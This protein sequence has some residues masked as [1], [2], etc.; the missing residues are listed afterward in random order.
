MVPLTA[1]TVW[2]FVVSAAEPASPALNA[3]TPAVAP[4]AKPAPTAETLSSI[5]SAYSER[6]GSVLLQFGYDQFGEEPPRR[7]GSGGVQADYTLGPGDE[8]LVTLRGQKSSSKRHV[9]DATGLLTA[10]DVRPVVAQGLTLADLRAQL[11]NAVTASF[12]DT[13]VYVSVTEIRR[14]GVLVT[15]AVARPGRQEV[16]AF[17]TLIDALTAAGG[18]TRAGSLRRIRLFHAHAAGGTVTGGAPSNGLPIDLYDLF[19]TG[20][21]ANAGIRLRDGDRVFVPPLGPTVALAGPFKRP[22][23]YELPPGEDRLPVAVATEMAGGL[24]RPGSHRALRYAI[25][26]NGEERVEEL[27]E[28]DAPP[29]TDGDLLLLAPRRENRSGGLRLDGHVLRPG[30]RALERTPTIATLVTA[31]DLG[32]APYLPFAVLAS[33]S[34]DSRARVLRPIDLRAVLNGRDRRPLAESD[35]LYVLGADEVDFLTSEPVLDLLRGAREPAANACRGLVVLARALTAQPDGPLANGPQARAAAGLTGGRTPCPPLFEAV[36]DLL[37]FALEHSSLLMGGVARPGFYP[38]AA[39][40]SAAALALAAGGPASGPYDD[41]PMV[42][43]ATQRRPAVA[44]AILEPDVPVYELTGHARRPGVRPLAG[45]ATLRDA[46]AGGDAL[47]RD[48]YP[49][50]GVIERFDRRT[51]AHRLF[52]FSPREVASGQANRALADG[53]RVWLLSSAEVRLL[54]GP[55]DKDSKP[56]PPQGDAGPP[57]A[58]P[59]LPDSVAALVRERGVQVRG[60]VR[61]PGTYPV[62][63]TATIDALIATAGGLSATADLASL[64]VTTTTGQR[65]RLDL[66]DGASAR[67]ALHPGDSLRVNPTPR[68]LEAR[69]VTISGAVRRPGSYDVA[70]GETLSSLIDRAGGLTEEAYPAGT[71]FLRDSER[72]RERAWFDQQARDL[73]RWMVQEVEKGEA[74]RSDVVGLARQLATQLRGVEPLGRI[75][76]EADPQMLRRRPELDVLLEPDDRILIPKRP[77]TVTVTGEVLHPTAAQFVSGKTAEAYLREAGG[78]SRNADDARIFLILPDGRAQ[79][80][81]LS[82]WNHTVTAIPPGSAI[83]VPRDPKPFDLMEF[84]KNIGTILGQLAISAAAIAVI[85][86]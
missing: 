68:T 67:T 21:G 82:S 35:T 49:L 28:T 61:A 11:A 22:G 54:A 59:P 50:L 76:V 32:P 70:R 80:L 10:D 19:M 62:A 77:L 51:L 57:D 64:E 40:G 78:A 42:G 9:I 66:R 37:V 44:G 55:S 4:Q 34:P 26:P 43:G 36:P 38:S 8:L 45:G 3:R 5:E 31:A 17:A 74:A 41:I 72:K 27:A 56:E 85:S 86:E 13:E 15:G 71:S 73:E 58:G 79:P 47:K 33:T 6:A 63:E 84:S 29:L 14:I 30:P 12:P 52:P 75:V 23:V 18:V 25:G 48:V 69:A 1:L 65:R 20:D 46:L 16:G 7:D 39:R 60:A 83:V 81:S 2:G 53:D 24:L